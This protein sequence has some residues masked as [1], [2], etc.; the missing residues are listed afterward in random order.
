MKTDV[1]FKT[2]P[3]KRFQV[4]T[5]HSLDIFLSI[6]HG[7]M[8]NTEDYVALHDTYKTVYDAVLIVITEENIF[9]GTEG[10][11]SYAEICIAK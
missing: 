3:T 8:N 2:I 7:K 1:C 10:R 4:Y 6:I 9:K 11:N 5:R